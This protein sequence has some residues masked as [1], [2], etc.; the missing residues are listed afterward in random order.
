MPLGRTPQVGNHI[1]GHQHVYGGTDGV[2]A[3]QDVQRVML[4][5]GERPPREKQIDRDASGNALLA[6]IAAMLAARR[7]SEPGA[8]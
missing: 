3:S 8:W 4:E 5:T 7:E 2:Q 1:L 6:D